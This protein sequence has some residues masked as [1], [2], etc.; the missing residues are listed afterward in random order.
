MSGDT[1]VAP[2]PAGAAA[3][4]AAHRNRL[5]GLLVILAG[6]VMLLAGA[7]TWTMIRD[8]LADEKITVAEDARWFGGDVVDGPLTAYAQAD[9]INHHAMEASGG[10]TYAELDREDPVRATMMN[11][12]FLRA[13][14]FTSVLAFGVSAMAMGL[15]LVLVLIGWALMP[16]GRAATAPP[17]AAA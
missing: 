7:T 10:R 13:S 15:G 14:L 1:A 17:P 2:T 16:P 5:L 6:A 11:A 8:Q 3:A 9:I 12:S 4:H